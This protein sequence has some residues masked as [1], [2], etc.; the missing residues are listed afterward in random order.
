M[1]SALLTKINRK[2][3]NT[4]TKEINPDSATRV[5]PI[6]SPRVKQTILVPLELL[7]KACSSIVQILPSDIVPMSCV[8]G[9]RMWTSGG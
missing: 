7:D 6:V 4:A 1:G 9:L 5:S 3:P 8:G 2:T